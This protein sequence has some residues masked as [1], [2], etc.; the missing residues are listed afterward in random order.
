LLGCENYRFHDRGPGLSTGYWKWPHAQ[1]SLLYTPVLLRRGYSPT[2]RIIL[3]VGSLLF[4][5][6]L[7]V[8]CA[9]SLYRK[10]RGDETV[11]SGRG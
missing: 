2:T 1:S 6:A 9:I 7:A 3:T 4:F 11:T 5:F 8:Y 10:K